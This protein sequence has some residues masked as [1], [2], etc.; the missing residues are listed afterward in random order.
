MADNEIIIEVVAKL[1]N[2]DNS[3]KKIEDKAE[4]TGKEIDKDLGKGLG[5]KISTGFKVGAAAIVASLAVIGAAAF[6]LRTAAIEA[7]SVQEDAVNQLNQSLKSAGDFSLEASR[8]MQ[9]YAASI[10][11]TTTI[12]DEAVINQ[13]ALARGFART[14][15]EAVKLVDAAI[16]MSAFT[17]NDLR[18]SVVNLGKSLGGLVGELGETVAET[19][20]LTTEQ[21]KAGGAIDLVKTKFDSFAAAQVNT[22]SGANKQLANTFGT[23]LEEIGF[24]ITKAPG[25]TASFKFISEKVR[26]L[27]KAVTEF[28]NSGGLKTFSDGAFSVARF[29]TS[30]LGPVFE[31][32]LGLSKLIITSFIRLGS[33]IANLLSGEFTKAFDGIKEQASSNFEFITEIFETPGTDAAVGFLDGFQKAIEEAPPVLEDF[34]NKTKKEVKAAGAEFKA[35]GTLIGT[36]V[37]SLISGSLAS[38]GGALVKGGSAFGAFA[39]T[40]ANIMGDFFISLGTSIIAADTAIVALKA[41]LL[42]FFGGGGIAAGIGLVIA[43]GALKAFAGGPSSAPGASASTTSAAAT[44]AAPIGETLSSNFDT[45]AKEPGTSVTVNIEGNVLDRR[46]TGLEIANVLNEVFSTNGIVIAKGALS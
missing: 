27:T 10:E 39:K 40:A 30:V 12:G 5:K 23:L 14:N 13:L 3:L 41:S 35:L 16:E 20:D 42:S 38:L 17:G 22:Y 9:A 15:E 1:D 34:K 31:K 25:V 29:F 2:V 37:N 45:E 32:T 26:D 19:R 18:S 11:A 46:E 24:L 28:R 7:A 43:G 33:V 8:S 36:T 44:D 21:L 6:K 4:K